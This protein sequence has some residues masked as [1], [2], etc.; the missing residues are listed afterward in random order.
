MRAAGVLF[1]VVTAAASGCQPTPRSG[2]FRCDVDGDCPPDQRCVSG[3]CF[4]APDRPEED[5]GYDGGDH[6]VP[7]AGSDDASH[8]DAGLLDAGPPCMRRPVSFTPVA[9]TAIIDNP[10]DCNGA[11]YHGKEPF[12]NVGLGRALLRFVLN[13]DVLEAW[14]GG[15]VVE[16]DLRL[17]R[18]AGCGSGDC[19]ATAGALEAHPL[20][21]DWDEGPAPFDDYEGA[22]WCRRTAQSR[23]GQEWEMD[24]ASAPGTDVGAVSGSIT[25]G[26]GESGV[27]I[28]LDP[29]LHR[30][31]V[32]TA[33]AEITLAVAVWPVDGT[34]F[35]ASS[36]ES[37][38]RTPELTVTV[39]D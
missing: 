15:H 2:W 9:D 19:P 13:A 7:D 33:T 16:L 26:I 35:V 29:D 23:G 4:R 31:F 6:D 30:P 8:T 39:C 11:N 25:V 38:G 24:G 3:T 20:R 34:V 28:A 32:S 18:Q 14:D 27:E 22:D 17:G 36:R 37:G 21:V 10:S 5:A 12:M 1:L